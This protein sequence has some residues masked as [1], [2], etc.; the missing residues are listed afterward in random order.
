MQAL[1]AEREEYVQPP[2][3]GLADRLVRTVVGTSQLAA[4]RLF[5]F[6]DA[7]GPS[8]QV[9]FQHPIGL[10][11][12]QGRIYVADT[13]NNKIRVVNPKTGD[14]DHLGGHGPAG[15]QRRPGPVRRAGRD[16]GRRAASSTSPT[17]TTT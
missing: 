2:A 3:S 16:H 15:P 4:N 12:A 14:H 8:G 11:Y 1:H 17:P 6:G 5:T 10:V 9:L 7:D 13:Y